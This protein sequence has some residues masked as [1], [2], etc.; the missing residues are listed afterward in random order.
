MN[1][2]EQIARKCLEFL[3]AEGAT[4]GSCSAA[5]GTKTEF[6]YESGE[7]GLLRTVEN[8]A[9]S[10]K[11]L[12]GTKKGVASLNSF[13]EADLKRAAAEAV[14]AAEISKEDPA[15]GLPDEI[16]VK[17][18]QSGPLK[19]DREEMLFRL[20]EFFDELKKNYP[21]I[22]V[23]SASISHS[24]EESVYCTTNG[25]CFHSTNGLY[26]FSPMFMARKGEKTSSFNHYGA[27]FAAPD[28]PLADLADG[29]RALSDSIL[30]VEPVPM[31]GKFTGDVIFTPGCFE[32]L[33]GSVEGLFL[34]EGALID[35]TSIW[36]D[37]LN[38]QVA[39]PCFTW[40]SRP[41]SEEI[42][43]GYCTAG[44]YEAHDM[45]MI[46]DGVL[47]NF[48]LSR[49]GAK[50][51]GRERSASA[52][53][54]YFVE[55]GETSLQQMIAGVSHGLLVDRFS[56]GSPAGDGTISGIAKNSFEIRDGKIVNAVNEAMI[57]G[58][59]A[60]MMQDISEISSERVNDGSSVLPW[61]KVKNVVI[62]GQ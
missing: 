3:L 18:F 52:G 29:R 58:N 4:E 13:E 14:R 40:S 42:V 17:T 22:S 47:V 15:E 57:S 51:T 36:K 50:K 35:G 34:S 12:V 37:K 41:R 43:G 19:P 9:V 46:R 31:E 16:A 21:A 60:Q 32:S 39:A 56:G 11:A 7:L 8:V 45:D 6:Y 23:D 30:Q 61:V 33:L 48:I 25:I 54:C 5:A 49:Y 55:P 44:G 24:A 20:Q 28:R 10:V 38:T 53:G 59:L 1:R 62:S 27:V 26:S 2:I